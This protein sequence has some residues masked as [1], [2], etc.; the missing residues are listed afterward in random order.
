MIDSKIR[1]KDRIYSELP[2]ELKILMGKYVLSENEH[3]R[4]LEDIKIDG[5]MGKTPVEKPEFTIILGQTGSG[6]TNLATYLYRTNPNNVCIDSDK[7]KSFRGDNDE[8]LRKHLIY[9]GYLTAPDSYLHRDEMIEDAIE[10]KYNIMLDCA[11]SEKDGLFVNVDELIKSGYKVNL[12]TMAVSRLN[13]LLS[14]HERYEANLV[15]KNRTSKLTSIARHDDSFG[16]L[17]KIIQEMQNKKGVN[18]EI[19]ERGKDVLH[20]PQKIY[21][22]LEHGERRYSCA[23]QALIETQQRDFR[24][25]LNNFE[26]RYNALVQLMNVRNASEEQRKQLE[27]IREE[28]QKAIL[29]ENRRGE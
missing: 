25:A 13:S 5:Y 8:I 6:K 23:Y 24:D 4:I 17:S 11:P 7:Y 18:I 12:E 1:A 9:Y 22:S 21:S 19:F 2:E 26:T 16:V 3:M 27:E 29:P 10:K 15:L 28:Y 20:T 14:V